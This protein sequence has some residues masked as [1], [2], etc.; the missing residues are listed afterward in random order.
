MKTDLI[1]VWL[2]DNLREN[3]LVED[4]CELLPD[5]FED[6]RAQTFLQQIQLFLR[7]IGVMINDE[8]FVH[9]LSFD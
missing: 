6:V 7:C 9:F 3:E 5:T 8:K 1:K 2:V 4:S